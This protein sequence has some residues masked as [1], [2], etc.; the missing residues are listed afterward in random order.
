MKKL[1]LCL[2]VFTSFSALKAQNDDQFEKLAQDLLILVTDTGELP[3]L[4]YIRIKTYRDMADQQDWPQSEK[5][6]FK[7]DIEAKYGLE[8]ELFH[9]KLGVLIERYY[10]EAVDGAS[11]EYLSS[12]YQVKANFKNTFTAQMRFLYSYKGMQSMVTFKYELFFNGKGLGFFGPPI[13]EEF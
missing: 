3:R 6:E 9:K 2:L 5:E 7:Y 11:V 10:L 8:Y 12:A 13:K 4:E 1:L